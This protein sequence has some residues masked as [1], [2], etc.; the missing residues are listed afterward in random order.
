MRRVP[1]VDTLQLLLEVV[2]SG[3]IS[4][5][6]RACGVSQQSASS[7]VRTAERILGMELLVR[8]PAGVTT[9]PLAAAVLE[10]AARVTEAAEALQRVVEEAAGRTRRDL[11]VAASQTVAAHLLPAWLLA[12]REEQQAGGSTPTRIHV[13]PANSTEVAELVRTGAA[14]L[15]FIESPTVPTDLASATVAHDALV[16]VVASGHPWASRAQVPL[17][18]LADVALISRET[19]SGTRD[20]W[21][22][23]VL[24]RLGRPPAPPALVLDSTP[25]LRSAVV[26]GEGAAVLS[27]LTVADDVQLGRSRIVPVEG[28]AIDRPITA[29]WRGAARDLSPVSR[30]L[31]DA[32]A[33]TP[34]PG[35]P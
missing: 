27:R 18:E 5:G 2:R 15:G 19:G 6:A 28:G 7:R 34:G 33:R 14:D 1:D 16:L 35:S 4:A 23:A 3:S 32:A 30:D 24:H 31:I 12:F 13:L 22:R 11:S 26:R 8:S 9:T 10:Q 21:E 29:L 20:A 25:A 17:A